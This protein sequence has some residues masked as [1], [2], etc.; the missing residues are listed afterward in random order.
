MVQ[1]GNKFRVSTKRL[2]INE[3]SEA[4]VTTEAGGARKVTW[5]LLRD[6]QESTLAVDQLRCTFAAPLLHWTTTATLPRT[7]AYPHRLRT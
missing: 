6:G 5:T 3:G 2:T 7:A 1:P 4:T